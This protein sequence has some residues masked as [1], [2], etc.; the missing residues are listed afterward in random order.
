MNVIYRPKGRALEYA[1]LAC[2][3][4]MG[5]AHGCVYCYA[6]GCL[7]RTL[8]SWKETVE[9]RKNVISSF[10]KDVIWLSQ[11][12][13][14]DD[15][16]RV[17]FCFLSDPYQPLESE[18]HVTRECIEIASKHGEKID[19]LIKGTYALV[20]QDFDLMKRAGVHLGVTLG[21]IDDI[22]R[23]QWEPN[24]SSVQDRLNILKEAHERGIYTW[25][26]MEPVIDPSDAL[27]VIEKAAPF[28]DFWKIG[29]LNYNK[30]VEDK[31]DWHKF[32]WD[33]RRLL[34]QHNAKAYIKKS[35]KAFARKPSAK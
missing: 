11:N 27:S 17:L 2:N 16:R 30:A 23:Q 35:L 29:K 12:R 19:I 22:K 34:K 26:S 7:R 25:V 28:V 4:Y 5:C 9:A 15:K 31:V 24:A 3:L 21:F 33:V 14:D 20:S 18:L 32:Y 13:P 8:D 10:T 1:P 6:P